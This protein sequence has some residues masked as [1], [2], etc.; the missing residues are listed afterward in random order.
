MPLSFSLIGIT[1]L[2][3]STKDIEDSRRVHRYTKNGTVLTI[4]KPQ[5]YQTNGVNDVV[6][7][8]QVKSLPLNL[9]CRRIEDFNLQ[10]WQLPNCNRKEVYGINTQ[11]LSLHCQRH[12]HTDTYSSRNKLWK[13]KVHHSRV[14]ST[15]KS[16]ETA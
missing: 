14:M 5:L 1:L 2:T 4:Q 6:W 13:P 15:S 3:Q 11:T 7:A 9:N 12:I 8:C 16:Y 10:T